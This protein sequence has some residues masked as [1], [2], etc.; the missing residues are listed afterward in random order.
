MTQVKLSAIQNIPTETQVGMEIQHWLTEY[1]LSQNPPCHISAQVQFHK[2]VMVS[3]YLP[4]Y[5]VQQPG[6]A[7]VYVGGG[8]FPI[9]RSIQLLHV[10]WYVQWDLIVDTIQEYVMFH[11]GILSNPPSDVSKKFVN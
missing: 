8:R 1:P 10:R 2:K 9:N 6:Q 5:L 11:V 3:R 7:L 4:I